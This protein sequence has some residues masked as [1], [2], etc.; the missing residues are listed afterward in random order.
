M[1]AIFAI[2]RSHSFLVIVF[3]LLAHAVNATQ[4]HKH[5][6]LMTY[7]SNDTT[8]YASYPI[9]GSLNQSGTLQHNEALLQQ[10][11]AV[12][13]LGYAFLQVDGSGHVYFSRPSV[14]LS[15]SDITGFC[16]KQPSSCPH[17]VNAWSGNFSAFARL[18]N[19]DHSL[20]KVISIG[21]A[22]SQKTFENAIHNPE[23]FIQS[24]TYLIHAYHLNGIDLDFEPDAFFY[25]HEGQSYAQLVLDL[26]RALGKEAF[27]S[28]EVPGD[29]ETLRSVNCPTNN[30]C[31]NNLGIIA[32]NA[33]VSLM[34][35]DFHGP[36]YPG[37]V[38]SND[39]NLYCDPDEP[40]LSN[41]YHASV[42][43]AIGYLTF[44][45]VPAKKIIL[46]FPAYFRAYG[47]VEVAP[48]SYGLYQPFDKS[49]TPAY[50]LGTKGK[51]SYRVARRLLKSG[52]TQH[53]LLVNDKISAV[54]AYNESTQQWIS[55]DDQVSITSKAKYVLS[56]RL[57][58]MMMWEIGEDMPINSPTSLLRSAHTALFNT[59]TGQ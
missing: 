22:G 44:N 41:Y 34:G 37:M 40:L 9:P 43:Q 35:F 20:Q 58:G 48:G 49:K 4:A 31:S 28:I 21:G 24:A 42:N 30:S 17:V 53:Y 3:L 52:F 13:V 23:T 54:Y 56:R 36:Y 19:R 2:I 47:G 38:T 59:K 14:D 51:G 45:K 39:S 15:E 7:W 46:G 57:A 27:I 5:I 25:L 18:D 6:I 33:Y 1:K 26:R 8:K 10:L 55:Y 29:W 16:V 12:N 11:N 50:D 32:D